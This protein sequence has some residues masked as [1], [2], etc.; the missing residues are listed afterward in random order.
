MNKSETLGELATAL[1]QV[2]GA[3]RPAEEN[4]TNPFFK[5][6]YADLASIISAARAY[7]AANGLSVSQFPG[8]TYNGDS[9]HYATLTTI[10]MHSSGEWISQD[11]TMPLAKV[12]PQG[13]GSAI[14]YARRYALASVL[15]IVAG[16]DDDANA[17]TQPAKAATRRPL[18]PELEK[19]YAHGLGAEVRMSTAKPLAVPSAVIKPAPVHNTQRQP[20]PGRLATFAET[21]TKPAQADDNRKL[22]RDEYLNVIVANLGYK[23]VPHVIA[24]MKV[25]G[26]DKVIPEDSDARRKIYEALKEYRAYRDQGLPQDEALQAMADREAQDA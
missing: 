16:E 1:A 2:Q 8:P 15:G 23:N 12:D 11:L 19:E 10:L 6:K 4:A 26:F 18:T 20:Q 14:T 7:M 13:Y 3:L 24:T 25:I 5:S 22:T 21:S 17:A 9:H